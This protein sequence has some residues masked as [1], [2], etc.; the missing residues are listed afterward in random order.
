MITDIA[1]VKQTVSPVSVKLDDNGVADHLD[2]FVDAGLSPAQCLRV[3]IHTHPGRCPEPSHTDEG[4]FARV[5]GSS[6]WAVMFV[7]S[8]TGEVYARLR[9]NV[10][11]GGEAELPVE[12][13]FRQPFAGSDQEAW[14]AEY[15]ANVTQRPLRLPASLRSTVHVDEDPPWDDDWPEL[16]TGCD[17]EADLWWW[18][19][20]EE[21]ADAE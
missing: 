18:E 17:D 20:D 1:I 4:C 6:D 21:V 13:N 3:W 10:G 15:D 2:R 5:F 8:R 12:V 7:V 16:E 19:T 14:A 11:P 9:F